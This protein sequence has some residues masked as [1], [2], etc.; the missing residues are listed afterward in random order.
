MIQSQ[1]LSKIQEPKEYKQTLSRI[2]NTLIKEGFILTYF[3]EIKSYY[4]EA[5]PG[6]WGH[7]TNIAPPWIEFSWYYWPNV[8]KHLGNGS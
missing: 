1:A 6:S 4:P 5:L 8:L 2:M 7:F 3:S